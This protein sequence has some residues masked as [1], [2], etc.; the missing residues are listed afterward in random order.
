MHEATRRL[1]YEGVFVYQRG[2][3]VESMRLIHRYADGVEAERL[4][5][6]SGPAREVIRQGDRVTCVYA[7]SDAA[8]GAG[9][10]PPRD[11]I[12]VGFS[13]PVDK[14]DDNYHITL[15]G[16]DRVAG[17]PSTVVAVTPVSPDRYGYRLWLDEESKLLLKSA[18]LD[19]S[20]RALEQMQFT[21]LAVHASLAAERLQPELRG[22]SF[23]WPTAAESKS[24]D[25]APP[26]GGGWRVSW[27]PAGFEF[28]ERSLQRMGAREAPIDHLVYSDGVAMVSVFVEAVA[29]M[30][31]A[32]RGRSSRGA[33]NAF[34]RLADNHQIT[35]VG[36]VPAD[37]AQKIALSVVRA[38]P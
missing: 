16:Q 8:R 31:R 24:A 7:D 13:A 36:E 12:G 20:G 17:R 2:D 33:V 19:G 28:K 25:S 3:Q 22:P 38:E 32:L 15:D 26:A 29:D 18:I 5:S 6:L 34:S 9:K 27:V 21:D 11:L 14:L 30:K 23:D 37:T 1:N 4:V 10:T 35:V